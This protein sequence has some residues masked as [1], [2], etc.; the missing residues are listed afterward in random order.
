MTITEEMLQ[1]S[2]KNGVSTQDLIDILALKLQ[3]ETMVP[4]EYARKFVRLVTEMSR[5]HREGP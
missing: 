3:T 4:L 5:L 1:A 2:I